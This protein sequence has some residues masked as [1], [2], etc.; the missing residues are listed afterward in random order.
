MKIRFFFHLLL[1]TCAAIVCGAQARDTA[2]PT[3]P[4]G[5]YGD[6]F[7]R[8]LNGGDRPAL[9]KFV[10]ENFA[11][12][13]DAAERVQFLSRL[14]EQSR[15]LQPM[16]V[17]PDSN[18]RF[19]VVDAKSKAGA[20]WARLFISLTRVQPY[21]IVDIGAFGIPDPE[22]ARSAPWPENITDERAAIKEIRKR[23]AAESMADR[24]SG[25]VLVAKGDTTLFAHA[26]GY[27][28]KGHSVPNRLDTKFN[29]ASMN[30]MFTAVAIGQLIEAG[31]LHLHD[32]LIDVLPE[33][34]N[35]D[36]GAKI[37]VIDLLTH[38]SGL[39]DF[40]DNPAFRPHRER[41]VHPRDYLPLFASDPLR[42]EPGTRFSY[43]NAGFVVLGAIVEAVSGEDYFDYI[44]AHIYRP[45]GMTET[46]SY[47]L[48]QVV[49]N[50][51]IGYARFED[52][53]LGI[54]PRRSNIAFLPWRGSP[55]GGGYSTAGDLM[56]FISAL[57]RNKLLSAPMTKQFL[58]PQTPMTG[59]Y[60]PGKYGLGFTVEEFGDKTV[61]GHG[62]G[63]EHSGIAC[64]LK[65]FSDGTYTVIVLGNY[66]PPAAL[67]L[68]YE[69]TK[70]LARL[71]K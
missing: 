57:R 49:S 56:K 43:S 68:S 66:D 39:G 2:L 35:K 44:R 45:A 12:A 4:V 32:R 28:D 25:V 48:T 37:K 53:P 65:A 20:H 41:F 16:V 36:A 19:L 11:D 9:E 21:K 63:G 5:K 52:D 69:I 27:A 58:T 40:F 31:K 59:S 22:A 50:L 62:G 42:F 64:D 14:Y 60:R 23:A 51:A 71:K 55:A 13:G 26:Y 29:L 38:R 1:F 46:D 18:E 24:F 30:K 47:E 6:E 8:V 10:K 17:S 70:L 54:E 67:D 7:L 61:I 34:P 33:Y 15:G 3:T